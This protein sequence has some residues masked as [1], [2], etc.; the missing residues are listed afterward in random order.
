M[1]SHLVITIFVSTLSLFLG[2]LTAA[3]AMHN[4]L[5]KHVMRASQPNFFDVTP[6]GRILNRFS[7]DV[8]EV[9]NDLPSTLRA[10][11][12]CFFGVHTYIRLWSIITYIKNCRGW[13]GLQWTSIGVGLYVIGMHKRILRNEMRLKQR[14]THFI[15]CHHIKY[16]INRSQPSLCTLGAFWSTSVLCGHPRPCTMASWWA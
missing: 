8:E 6:V 4:Y 14:Y 7:A 2:C 1:Y 15:T 5:L 13:V 3:R 9:D 11:T 10:W 12:A 16:A